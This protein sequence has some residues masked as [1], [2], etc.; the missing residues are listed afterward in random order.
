MRVLVSWKRISLR[1]YWKIWLSA[2]GGKGPIGALPR[3]DAHFQFTS[4]VWLK[5]NQ[6]DTNSITP[7]SRWTSANKSG[8]KV[9]KFTTHLLNYLNIFLYNYIVLSSSLSELNVWGY[10][11]GEYFG[12]TICVGSLLKSKRSERCKT[13]RTKEHSKQNSTNKIKF[14]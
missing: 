3:I 11:F 12:P 2:L 14:I 10:Y 7:V 8:Q 9:I 13:T 6:A 1:S 4:I 5:R